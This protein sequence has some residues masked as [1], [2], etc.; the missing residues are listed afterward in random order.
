MDNAKL[1]R[2]TS[3]GISRDYPREISDARK[4]L[5]PEFKAARDKYG[6]QNVK[7]VFPA[8]LMIRGETVNNFFPDWHSTLRGSRNADVTAHVEQ[9]FQQLTACLPPQ[10]AKACVDAH[11]VTQ[12]SGVKARSEQRHNQ[13]PSG[14]SHELRESCVEPGKHTQEPEHI[15]SASDGSDQETIPEAQRSA[16]TISGDASPASK[17]KRPAR[18]T[19][20]ELGYLMKVHPAMSSMSSKSPTNRTEDKA[21]SD[22]NINLIQ[23]SI[24]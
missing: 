15:D 24:V 7:L 6:A 5:W 8:A 4:Q 9:R 21:P 11:Q 19:N 2:G 20:P 22:S 10:A 16:N 14:I 1:L 13:F 23:S 3:F 12:E 17:G 18:V